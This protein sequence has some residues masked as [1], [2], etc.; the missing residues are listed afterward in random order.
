MNSPAQDYT[1]VIWGGIFVRST[2]QVV[3][4]QSAWININD[5]EITGLQSGLVNIANQANGLQLGFVNYAKNLNGV[6]IGFVN[7]VESNEWFTGLP[8]ELAKGFPI[9]NWSF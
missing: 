1:G 9:V 8:T 3:G 2:G 4:W 6:Q 7:V 5:Q